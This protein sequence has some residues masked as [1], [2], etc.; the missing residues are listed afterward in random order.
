MTARFVG[1][2][3]LA[4]NA[5]VDE[6]VSTTTRLD[7]DKLQHCYQAGTNFGLAIGA[8]PVAAEH[9][10]HVATSAGTIR[11]FHA[12]LND[13]GTT[14]NVG[15]VLKKNGT[16]LMAS[17]LSIT[18]ASADRLVVDGSLSNSTIAA[19]DVLSIQLTV[20]SS[21]GAQ[22]PFAWVDIEETNAP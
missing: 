22:G 6:N 19:D 12:M 3:T 11:G 5:V 13:T 15:F 18:E 1:D 10:V 9:I 4:R 14:T 17:P 2:L 8:T 20:T 21:T 7:A 16:T